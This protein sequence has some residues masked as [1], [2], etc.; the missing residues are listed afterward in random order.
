MLMFLYH[1]SHK[2]ALH[3]FIIFSSDFRKFLTYHFQQ[4]ILW[5]VSEVDKFF[6]V[7]YPNLSYR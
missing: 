5:L 4:D 7:F 6:Y 3:N 2:I 1:S